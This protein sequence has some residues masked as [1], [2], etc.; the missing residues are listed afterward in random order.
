[1]EYNKY[2]DTIGKFTD[3][4]SLL[5]SYS[6]ATIF[7]RKVATRVTSITE[8]PYWIKRNTQSAELSV[9]TP[10]QAKFIKPVD[11]AIL[12]MIPES[13][14]DLTA[15]LNE[16]LRTN[17]LEQQNNTIWFPTPENPDKTEDHTQI[18]TRNLKDLYE[19]KEKKPNPKD[20]TKSRKKFLE[21][22]DWT[23]TLLTENE[24]QAIEDILTDYH[25]IF[26]RHRIDI[27]MN[28]ELKVK[29]TPKRRQ[30]GI[31]P[32]SAHAY[33]PKRSSHC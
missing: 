20:D 26:A 31:Q 25:D 11:M 10:E 9:V 5:I 8:T 21:K 2:Y 23:K 4:A 19:L 6:M 32:K 7:N 17:K 28:T 33:P 16:L 12:S 18:Q 24:K 27:G 14:P 3:A 22:F 29:L 15:Y 30:S 13:N 1:M